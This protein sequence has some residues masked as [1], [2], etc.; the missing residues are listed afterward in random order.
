[1][2]Y[3]EIGVTP[4]S[5]ALGAVISGIDL[6][7]EP[8][9]RAMAELEDAFGRYSVIFFRDQNLTPQQHI[10]MAERW[11]AINV[12]RFFN[13]LDGYPQIAQ[14]IKE[15]NQ[16]ENIGG[17]WHTDHSYDLIPAMGSMLYAR[18]VPTVGGDTLFSSMYLAYE[19]LSEDMKK[20][21]ADLKAWHSSRHA[22]GYSV[23]DSEHFE[24]GRLANPGQATQDALHPVVITHPL[25]GRKALYVNADF[26]V[27]FDGWT[28]EES[29]PILD[30]LYAHGARQ[31]FTCRFHWEPGSIAFWDNRATWHYAMNDYQGHRRIMHRIT[32]EGV[33][34]N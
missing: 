19:A 11:G 31:E 5:T 23:T 30:L 34:L 22:F 13:P 33:A 10:A 7:K 16:K 6:S 15:A 21:L 1:M 9:K 17:T 25:T 29:Q 4:Q 12:N 18:E 32:L 20:M 24:D 2:D 14:V 27:R 8:S 26:T 28:V 3:K